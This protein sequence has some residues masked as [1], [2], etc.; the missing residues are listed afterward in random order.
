MMFYCKYDKYF[1]SLSSNIIKKLYLLCFFSS[2]KCLVMLNYLNNQIPVIK[3]NQKIKILWDILILIII[4]F[5]FFVIP[6]QIS[7]DIYYDDQFEKYA[8]SKGYSEHII[9]FILLIPEIIMITD[10]TLKFITGY[11]ENGII[12]MSKEKI[13]KKYLKKGL[14]FDI[15]SYCPILI[16]GFYKDKVFTNSST[17]LLLK[18]LQLLVFCKM[19]RINTLLR[20][21]ED[22]IVL[23]GKH[24][25]LLNLVR[26]CFRIVFVAHINAC[27]WHGI[28]YYNDSEYNW[29][30]A[31]ELIDANWVS[32]YWNSLYWAVSVMV[33]MGVGDQMSPKNN[34]ELFFGVAI[35]LVSAFIFGYTLNSM[36]QIFD[37]M[38]RNETEFKYLLILS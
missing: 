29:L 34:V 28:A 32:K 20:N 19:K 17:G 4:C 38:S 5:Y 10:T 26:V 23:N 8:S 15:L 22:V 21:F 18:S 30:L 27:V 31:S 12:I 33:T 11:Y 16:Q 37:L 25:Y 36:R 6:L 13:I 14:I 1:G 9:S 2:D 7:F 3:P 35:L 24:D